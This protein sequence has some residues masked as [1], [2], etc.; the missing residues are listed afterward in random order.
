MKIFKNIN[1]AEWV[2]W[3][4]LRFCV[5]DAIMLAVILHYVG[6]LK[7][8]LAFVYLIPVITASRR[9]S[10]KKINI[11]LAVYFSSYTGLIILEGLRIIPPASIIPAFKMARGYFW[12]ASS[13]SIT[14]TMVMG[15]IVSRIIIL[16][17][18][19]EQKLAESREYAD[20]M[21]KPM[22]ETLIAV[23]SKGKIKT[24]SQ[25]TLELIG[26]KKE[27][28]IDK[29]LTFIFAR[30]ERPEE[31]KG[32]FKGTG[33]SALI[34]AG[35][36]R[37]FKMTYKA[38]DAE[39]ISVSFSGGLMHKDAA[40]KQPILGII[41]VAA[42]MRQIKKFV[43]DLK[44]S[45]SQ[46]QELSYDLEK[47]VQERTAELQILY[48]VSNSISYIL[49]YRL[50]IR[51]ITE[52][53]FRMID[54]DICGSLMFDA[55]TVNIILKPVYSESAKFTEAVKNALFLSLS[56]F[57]NENLNKK[58]LSTF[59]IPSTPD[60]FLKEG[61]QLDEI[62]SFFNVPF[63]V[64]GKTIGMFNISSCKENAFNEHD[65]RLLYTIVN[66]TSHAIERLRQLITAEK[67]K[68]ESM[69]E[70]MSEGVVMIDE[71][72]EVVVVNPRLRQLLNLGFK[73][74]ISAK[75]WEE[76]VNNLDLGE[77]LKKCRDSNCLVSKELSVS[78]QQETVCLHCDIAPTR[79]EKGRVIGIV[80][81]FRDIT[82]EREIDQM[83]TEFVSIVSHE[84]RTPLSIAKEGL[85][86]ILDGIAGPVTKK[87]GDVLIAAKNN[88]DRLTNI[89]DS[90]LDI[91]KIEAGKIGIKR[92]LIN[93]NNLISGL[94][95]SFC[96][97]AKDKGIELRVNLPQK[98]IDVYADAEKLIQIFTNL[99]TNAIKFTQKGWIE[100]LV[101]EKEDG[102]E[103]S[104]VDTGVGISGDDLPKVFDKFQQ[105]NRFPGAGEKGTGLGLSIA[106]ALVEMHYGE[107]W[108]E[109]SLGKGSKFSFTLPKY[110]TEAFF[111][112][113]VYSARK[114]AD[115]KNS[116][117]SLIMVSIADFQK[118]NSTLSRE[119]ISVLVRDIGGVLRAGLRRNDNVAFKEDTAEFLVLLSS[120]AR[121]GALVA[122][123]RLRRNLEDTL[124]KKQDMQG[125]SLHIS[126]VVYPDDSQNDEDLLKKL[127]VL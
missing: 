55:Q 76:K 93:L 110:T 11:L 94:I 21:I 82:K 83:K 75:I 31:E 107:I 29:P 4:F 103:C 58:D 71:F 113:H 7:A 41:G 97:R 127:K 32:I 123:A 47:K 26:Y 44:D 111:K 10:L 57:S 85:S 105:F 28:L 112:E 35:F 96:Q 36:V 13:I 87:Q 95:P 43:R 84:L 106:K 14:L 60:T 116:R 22:I 122:Q 9:F 16:R 52:S 46:L 67:S 54:Y 12:L 109:S 69:V 91:S 8:S 125:I 118:L 65:V 6:D 101:L 124:A 114:E 17:R 19:R 115:K 102:V 33:L 72:G 64:A 49:D 74:Q 68:L 88:I 78:I 1:M 98:Q 18:Q 5:F 104:V 42:D 27:E 108:A 86:L 89:I 40:T 92:G 23:D 45:H 62:R 15:L 38:K 25:A 48:E 34:G 66:Q 37:N 126:L 2:D 117:F 51:M 81:I 20:H 100:I 70:N 56:N 39:N 77:S 30:G 24:I 99:I 61:R 80:A 3:R 73:E 121:E 120:C 63:V 50:L 90:L 53:L 59:I 119:E 79:D